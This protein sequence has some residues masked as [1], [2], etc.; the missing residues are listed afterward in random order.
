M[1]QYK[2]RM[3]R[4]EMLSERRRLAGI[5]RAMEAGEELPPGTQ[6]PVDE[7]G[8]PLTLEQMK[9]RIEEI[10]GLLDRVHKD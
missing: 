2:N 6:L 9:E 8:Q 1:P 10:D 3:Y 7:Q 4:K 5:V